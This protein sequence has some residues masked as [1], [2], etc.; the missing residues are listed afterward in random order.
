[1]TNH[2]ILKFIFITHGMRCVEP[3]NTSHCTHSA[4]NTSA[5]LAVQAMEMYEF[6]SA[7]QRVYSFWQ[8]DLCD[9]Y[10]ELMKPVM[11]LDDS[12]P[13][14]VR[15]HFGLQV[16]VEGVRDFGIN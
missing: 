15:Y 10:I 11:A 6:A 7:T 16:V 2:S 8:Y 5:I 12:T 14:Q 1:M 9:V 4:S 3:Y 13:Q